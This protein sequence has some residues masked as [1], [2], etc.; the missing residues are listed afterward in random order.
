QDARK[1]IWNFIAAHFSMIESVSGK[2]YSGEPIAFYLEDSDI[3]DR[4]SRMTWLMKAEYRYDYYTSNLI[5]KF[6][7]ENNIT[8]KSITV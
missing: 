1:G 2:N 7:E 4:C 6:I 5:R 3:V 8:T